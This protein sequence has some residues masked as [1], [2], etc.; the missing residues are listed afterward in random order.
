MC[1]LLVSHVSVLMLFLAFFIRF[2]IVLL[3]YFYS[4]IAKL[5]KESFPQ[6]S[7]QSFL[8]VIPLLSTPLSPLE[9]E[10]SF[11]PQF[12]NVPFFCRQIFLPK[13]SFYFAEGGK[14]GRIFTAI[15]FGNCTKCLFQ[16]NVR[17]RTI[18][19]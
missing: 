1:R 11:F 10:F 16:F 18:Y 2:L 4:G 6:F 13:N 9:H 8:F 14:T 7:S 19:G 15:D 5:R 12:L 3:S 17:F